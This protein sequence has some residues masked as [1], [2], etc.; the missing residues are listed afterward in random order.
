M[1]KHLSINTHGRDFV[2]GDIHGCF[3]A[4]AQAM[5]YVGFDEHL[6]RLIS[7]GDLV[8]RGRESMKALHYLQQPWFHA[9]LG[10]HDWTH[11]WDN[12]PTFRLSNHDK[13]DTQWTIGIRDR[14]EYQHL[15]QRLQQLPL[16]MDI[17]TKQGLVG[18]VHAEV[19]PT[20]IHW[21]EVIKFV[22]QHSGMKEVSLDNYLLT[23]RSRPRKHAQLQYDRVVE[24]VRMVISGHSC[25]KRATWIGNSLFI[26][27]GMVYGINGLDDADSGLTLLNITDDACY[28]FPSNRNTGT[29]DMSKTSQSLLPNLTRIQP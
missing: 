29:L 4:L 9:V 19:R 12:T 17:E 11:A 10:N 2:V 16:I 8:D 3:S 14:E 28:Y 18:I 22:N 26:D 20:Y 24:G 21:D 13:S 23:G 1:I 6:D 7:V 5:D 25:M 27:T 15:S